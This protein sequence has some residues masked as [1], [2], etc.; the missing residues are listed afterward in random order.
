M[1]FGT[2][3]RPEPEVEDEDILDEEKVR[4]DI[5]NWKDPLLQPMQLVQASREQNRSYQA[6]WDVSEKAVVQLA[7]IDIPTVRSFE[8]GDGAFFMGVT[9]M[10]Y[11]QEISWDSPGYN[12]VWIIDAT[13]GD[14]RQVLTAIQYSP[15]ISPEG[16]Y[17][18]SGIEI[19]RYGSVW[20]QTQV[21]CLTLLLTSPSLWLTTSMI[22]P[23]HP[24]HTETKA[25]RKEKSNL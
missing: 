6:L 17:L 2:A 23:M 1:F 11:R 24:V 21:V 22:A 5:W 25:G 18:T 13:T 9:N 14:R 12:D 8:D 15:S 4:L 3:P 10:N 7:D 20:R 19:A 16:T